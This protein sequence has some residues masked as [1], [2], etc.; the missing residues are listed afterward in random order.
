[1]VVMR[2]VDFGSGSGSRSGDGELEVLVA[3]EPVV[4]IG[5]EELDAWIREIMHDEIVAAFRAQLPEMFGSIKT[6]MVEY[7]DEG[8]PL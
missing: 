7:F 8:M 5:T 6:A 3:P 1:M 2:R 4:Q